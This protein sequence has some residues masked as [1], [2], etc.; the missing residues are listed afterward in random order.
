MEAL[1]AAYL[2]EH[3][4][5][6]RSTLAAGG[7]GEAFGRSGGARLDPGSR[8]TARVAPAV[9]GDR[10]GSGSCWGRSLAAA[11]RACSSGGREIGRTVALKIVFADEPEEVLRFRWEA[12]ITGRLEPEHRRCTRWGAAGVE[13]A[14]FCDEEDF[15]KRPARGDSRGRWKL[16]R[17]VEAFRDVCRAVA[18]AHSRVI[19]RDLKPANGDGRRF[20][21]GVGGGLGLA[22]LIGEPGP[23]IGACGR[24]RGPSRARRSRNA[25]SRAI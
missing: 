7:C 5:A 3:A 23:G 11:P 4:R 2:E 24:G 12:R 25:R 1:V 20:R 6:G 15:G 9:A 10:A 21:R 14:V 19:H 17:L 18:F 13:V 22:R 8:D 16:R